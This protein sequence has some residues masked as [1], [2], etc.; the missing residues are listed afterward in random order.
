M[1]CGA[2][3]F[4]ENES[5]TINF[6]EISKEVLEEVSPRMRRCDGLG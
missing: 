4:T 6:P 2:G 1:A 5:D 3:M